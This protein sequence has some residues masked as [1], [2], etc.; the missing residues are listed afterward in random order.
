[1]PADQVGWR[2]AVILERC[3]E[4]VHA[5]LSKYVAL[6]A[7]PTD[8]LYV[9]TDR[10]TFARWIG[11]RTIR[12]SIGGA[13][14]FVRANGR[15]AVLINLDRI[16]VSRESAIEVVV[17]EELLHMRDQLDGDT[18]GHAHHGYDRI[19]HRVSR[20][21]DVP[22]AGIRSALLPVERR[23]VKYRYACPQCERRVDR[24]RK[25][26]WSCGRCSPTFDRRFILR[27]VEVL[28]VPATGAASEAAKPHG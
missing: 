11:R 5:L 18:R 2:V 14:C 15:H 20:L 25:G 21:T 8:H 13:Y 1:M 4:R 3:D 16:D 7:L 12:G 17:A 28:D 24:R 10:P 22:L 9:T 23:P 26:T 6:L 27:I 19:A